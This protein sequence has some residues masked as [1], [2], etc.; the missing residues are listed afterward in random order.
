[1][2]ARLSPFNFIYS[3]EADG[4]LLEFLSPISWSHYSFRSLFSLIRIF[5]A[6]MYLRYHLSC[7]PRL[8]LENKS[9]SSVRWSES[10]IISILTRSLSLKIRFLRYH[11]I[12]K[13]IPSPRTMVETSS[14]HSTVKEEPDHVPRPLDHVP[15]PLDH[16][17]RFVHSAGQLI[18]CVTV[19]FPFPARFSASIVVFEHCRGYCR[20]CQ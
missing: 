19:R 11:I 14:V 2:Q 12:I 16:V 3:A 8:S 5:P 4:R 15:R 9:H 7:D 13:S 17:P 18:A 1:M 10:T 20:A 6:S